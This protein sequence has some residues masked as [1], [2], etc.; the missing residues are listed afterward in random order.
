MSAQKDLNVGI[1]GCGMIGTDHL[2]TLTEAVS[3]SRVWA[4]SDADPARA[5]QAVEQV[6]PTIKIH[7]DPHALISD[8]D[9]DAVLVASTEETHEQ[10]VLACLAAAKPVLCEKPLAPTAEACLRVVEAEAQVGRKLVQIGYMRRF[11]PSYVEMKRVLDS[12]QLGEALF[13]HAVHR[14]AGYPDRYESDALITATGVHDIDI[15]RWLLGDEIVSVTTRNPKPSALVRD[16]FQDPQ[17]LILETAGGVI[18]DVEIFVNAHYGYDVRCELVAERGTVSLVPPTTAS[19][20]HS[21]VDGHP[22][23][24]DARPRFAAAFRDE[25][26]A[27]VNAATNKQV[28]GANAWD[29]Y[30]AAA[31]A[32]ACLES[33]G[34]HTRTDVR[35][36]PRPSLY[37]EDDK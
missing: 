36:A 9:I 22:V 35:L 10:F 3:G 1:I 26:Q 28:C 7:T 18:V 33:F 8:P 23:L 20:R 34:N 6:D 19:I 21:G 24:A 14:N 30:A 13:L 27:W 16:G 4:V 31:V 12:G 29:G 2:R 32:E 11:D 15:A 5:A 17:F 37:T 25:L